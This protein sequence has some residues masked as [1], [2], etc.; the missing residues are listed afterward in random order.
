MYFIPLN[1]VDEDYA[2]KIIAEK[3]KLKIF[4]RKCLIKRE[5]PK[6]EGYFTTKKTDRG[7]R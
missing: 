7:I 5:S 1:R 4:D 6:I 3:Y 2:L